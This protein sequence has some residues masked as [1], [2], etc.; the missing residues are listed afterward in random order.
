M[1]ALLSVKLYTKVRADIHTE[2]DGKSL[3]EEFVSHNEA[4]HDEVDDDIAS[5]SFAKQRHNRRR[6]TN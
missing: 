1:V 2:N 5:S 3:S 6:S 4:K